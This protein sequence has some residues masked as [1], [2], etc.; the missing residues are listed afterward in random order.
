MLYNAQK[1]GRGPMNVVLGPCCLRDE[2]LSTTA[3]GKEGKGQQLYGHTHAKNR[4]SL[5]AALDKLE[6]GAGRPG[7][8]LYVDH[9][10]FRAEPWWRARSCEWAFAGPGPWDREVCLHWGCM[11]DGKSSSANQH[12]CGWAQAGSLTG[13]PDSQ[14]VPR[15]QEPG[16]LGELGELGE[17]GRDHRD[18]EKLCC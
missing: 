4:R 1:K 17:L 11:L 7:H 3:S 5:G 14:D 2:T 15:V 16:P 6:K 18:S 9:C 10:I 13:A 8:L 12:A